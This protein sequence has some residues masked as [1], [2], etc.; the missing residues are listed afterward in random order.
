MTSAIHAVQMA[1]GRLPPAVALPRQA[2]RNRPVF[3]SSFAPPMPA[4]VLP[5]V[6]SLDCPLPISS[7]HVSGSPVRLAACTLSRL[8]SGRRAGGMRKGSG[9]CSAQDA[10]RLRKVPGALRGGAVRDARCRSVLQGRNSLSATPERAVR[11]AEV[12]AFGPAEQRQEQHS[13][14]EPA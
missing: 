4:L 2:R 9:R 1:G 7:P 5:V 11:G 13:G 12:A 6:L 14:D 10:V 8:L 3:S